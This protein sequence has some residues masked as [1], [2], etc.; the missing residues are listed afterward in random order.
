MTINP[1][2]GLTLQ[3]N[4][5]DYRLHLGFSVLADVQA[6]HG[7]EF[8]KLFNGDSG[9]VPNLALVRDLFLGALERY[10]GDEVDAYL[11]DDLIAQNADALGLLLTSSMPSA[12]GKAKPSRRR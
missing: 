7:G 9:P 12:E 10:H 6:K 5:K 11:V 8:D 3:A 2:G 4:G 1:T